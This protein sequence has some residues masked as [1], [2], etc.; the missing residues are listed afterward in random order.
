MSEIQRRLKEEFEI[1]LTYMDTRMLVLDLGIELR[2]TPKP[3][4]PKPVESTPEPTPGGKV[5]VTMD[6]LAIPG[7]VVSGKVV[8]SDGQGA[9]WLLDQ[10][11]RLGFDPDTA[12][13][14]PSR[15]DTED[16]QTQLNGILQKAGF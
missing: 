2:E 1:S 10:T 3:A 7:A 8:F 4:E 5:T 6:H 13:Y 12:G 14:R 11:G 15:A 16:F 9:V